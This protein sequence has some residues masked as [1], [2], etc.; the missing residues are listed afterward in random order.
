MNK[1]Y[2]SQIDT[3]WAS[4]PYPSQELPG[5]TIGSGGCGATVGAM[6]VSMLKET[7][8]PKEMGD[9][10]IANGIRVN[11]GTSNRAFDSFLTDKYGLKC[12][13]K[14]KLDEAVEHLGK[15][16]IVVARCTVNNGNLFTTGGH[17]IVLVRL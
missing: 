17:F 14:Y 16:G 10:F 6:V 9:I 8:S 15:G 11:G 2:Y 13:K 5:A 7:I 4:H 12:E 3:R 1:V